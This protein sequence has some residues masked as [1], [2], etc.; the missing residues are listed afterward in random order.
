M[1]SLL[2]VGTPT[3]GIF[4]T[5]T[6]GEIGT[7][8]PLVLLRTGSTPNVFLSALDSHF[9]RSLSISVLKAGYDTVELNFTILSYFILSAFE[10]SWSSTT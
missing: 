3:A 7:E 10:G 5:L 8:P 2:T 6:N 1:L 9:P 4:K